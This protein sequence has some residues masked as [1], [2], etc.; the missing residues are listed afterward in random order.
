MPEPC[1]E[2]TGT[3]L[4]VTFKKP[5]HPEDLEKLG[6]NERQI[7][8]V[9]YVVKQGSITNREYQTINNTTRYTA[10]RDLGGIVKEG[11][12]DKIGE[13]KR[14]LRYVLIQN[15]AKMRQKNTQKGD[16]SG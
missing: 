9:N 2:F 6:L 1:F 8:A 5:L 4:I 3:S 14:D 13:G 12:F 16:D 10:T 15:A 11:I 7:R